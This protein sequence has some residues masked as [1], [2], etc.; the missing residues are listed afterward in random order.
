MVHNSAVGRRWLLVEAACFGLAFATCLC[1]ITVCLVANFRPSGLSTA[2]WIEF[3]HLRSDTS[4]IIAFFAVAIFLPYSEFLRLRRRPRIGSRSDWLPS[5]D[6]AAA[7]G[8]AVSETLGGL[9]TGLVLYLSVNAVTHPA[10]M[11][12]QATHLAPWP[13]ESTLRVIALMM[14]AL[15]AT[16]YRLFSATRKS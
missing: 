6:N 7:A 11:A 16:V 14:C 2:Y 9:S 13:T 12:I 1:W 8:L 10:T 4:G 15:S 5:S 3:P